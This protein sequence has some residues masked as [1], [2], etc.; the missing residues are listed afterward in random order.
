M[1]DGGVRFD[2][3]GS[4]DLIVEVHS[5]GS[6]K[7]MRRTL[8]GWRTRN[9]SKDG[10]LIIDGDAT[11]ARGPAFPMRVVSETRENGKLSS[12]VVESD[13]DSDGIFET[14]SVMDIK[15]NTFNEWTLDPESDTWLRSGE[16]DVSLFTHQ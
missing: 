6:K 12:Y 9:F 10:D 2:S 15:K 13:M 5:D 3:D 16:P 14:R 7:I 1:L 4:P 11:P 8:D